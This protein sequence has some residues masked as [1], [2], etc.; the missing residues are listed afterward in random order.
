MHKGCK[1]ILPSKKK[2]NKKLLKR[3]NELKISPLL[4]KNFCLVGEKIFSR[5]A[6]M[7]ISFGLF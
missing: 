7:S 6:Q 1:D 3:D 5:N 2:R 4:E